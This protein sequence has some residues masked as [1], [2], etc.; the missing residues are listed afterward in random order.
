M[1]TENPDYTYACGNHMV[2]CRERLVRACW[3]NKTLD[4]PRF[5]LVGTP[6]AGVHCRSGSHF[7]SRDRERENTY[8]RYSV[9]RRP[10]ASRNT[11][12][13][14]RRS[15][16]VARAMCCDQSQ[17]EMSLFSFSTRLHLLYFALTNDVLDASFSFTLCV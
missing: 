2:S 4:R 1:L 10:Q 17:G 15:S 14:R 3:S 7:P 11:H 13:K 5:H 6:A 12:K 8:H 16:A 9:T